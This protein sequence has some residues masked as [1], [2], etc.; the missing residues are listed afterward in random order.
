MPQGKRYHCVRSVWQWKELLRKAV[1]LSSPESFQG[2]HPYFCA[3]Q[4][5]KSI[6]LRCH[7]ERLDTPPELPTMPNSSVHSYHRLHPTSSFNLNI[8]TTVVLGLPERQ[9]VNSAIAKHVLSIMFPKTGIYITSL[10]KCSKLVSRLG[11]EREDDGVLFPSS[12]HSSLA[13]CQLSLLVEVRPLTISGCV[14][15]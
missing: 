1:G 9:E 15:P 7:R 13:R 12:D 10:L 6:L 14:F 8:E 5:I 11:L 2:S 3:L 4:I